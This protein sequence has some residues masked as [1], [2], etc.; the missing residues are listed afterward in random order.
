MI[1]TFQAMACKGR[2]QPFQGSNSH[3]VFNSGKYI[4]SYLQTKI[5]NDKGGFQ[6]TVQWHPQESWRWIRH[7]I[8]LKQE[9]PS[10]WRSPCCHRVP[11]HVRSKL[12][13]HGGGN[14]L[15]ILITATSST[16]LLH[17][18]IQPISVHFP[19]FWRISKVETMKEF[20]LQY[21]NSTWWVRHWR[22]KYW[23]IQWVLWR[24]GWVGSPNWMPIQ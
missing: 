24:I 11:N 19:F 15:R 1:Q 22:S 12:L 23:C 17:G 20:K 21:G 2:I 9:L 10:I 8:K 4:K 7:G 18:L 14:R 5:L 3:M 16:N 13:R 6:G